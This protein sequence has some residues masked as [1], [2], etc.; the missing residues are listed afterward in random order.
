M[1]DGG[2]HTGLTAIVE[3]HGAKVAERQLQLTQTLLTGDLAR[4]TAVDLVRQPVF[5]GYGFELEHIFE[6]AVQI[7]FL[8]FYRRICFVDRLIF[9]DGTRRLTEHVLEFDIDGAYAILLLENKLHV[10]RRLTDNVHRSAFT[11]SDTPHTLNVFFFHQQPHTFLALVPDNFLRRKGWIADGELRHVDMSAGRF[12]KL[13]QTVQVSPRSMI[14]DRDDGV[15]FGL[16]D[17]TDHVGRPFLHLRIGTLHGIQLDTA[18]ILSRIDRRDSAS[19]HTDAV[20]I[21]S[22][23]H[24]FFLRLR[25]TFEGVA[26]VGIAH[27]SGQHDDFVVCIFLLV[28]GVLESEQR[29]A[30]QRLSELIPEIGSAVRCFDQDL[31]GR[32]I[33]PLTRIE[34]V[35]P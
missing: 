26:F 12:D 11:F 4:Y 34:Y 33:Q 28:L 16:G 2:S 30:D 35:L 20:I 23:D 27:T 24:H 29:P 13:G 25:I 31:F 8:I 10:I 18:C 19:T 17:G 14:V 5:A 15:T 1:T 3:R 9:H 22:D 21:T 7:G 32:L 6:V